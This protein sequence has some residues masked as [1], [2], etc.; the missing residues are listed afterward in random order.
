MVPV[1][2]DLQRP[3]VLGSYL[4][5]GDLLASDLTSLG[6]SFFIC[7]VGLTHL[8]LMPY[9]VVLRIERNNKNLDAVVC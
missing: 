4:L 2:L 3:G 6:L 8:I 1:R 9:W 5:L 7:D